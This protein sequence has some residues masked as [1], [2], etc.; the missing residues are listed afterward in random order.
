M[1]SWSGALSAAM[2]EAERENIRESTL[3]GLEAA[4][5]KG[6]NPSVASVYRALAEYEKRQWYPEPSRR[7]MPPSPTA[8][9]S[10]A[11]RTPIRQRDDR[12]P[13]RAAIDEYHQAAWL[14]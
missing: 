8:C 2:A 11:P 6:K 12:L 10:P 7:R 9:P 1:T 13:V 14:I 3:E 5:R 4:A